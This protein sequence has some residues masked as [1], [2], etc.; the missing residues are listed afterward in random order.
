MT[1]NTDN[2]QPESCKPRHGWFMHSSM[3]GGIWVVL[4]GVLFLINNFG[5]FKNEAF[6]KL[7]PVFI[8]VSGLFIILGSRRRC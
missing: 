4:V 1:T 6:A 7:W 3:Y 8:I 2:N 5:P